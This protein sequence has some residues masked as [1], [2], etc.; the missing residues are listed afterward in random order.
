MELLLDNSGQPRI[1]RT[2]VDYTIDLFEMIRLGQYDIVTQY[3][4]HVFKHEPQQKL[5]PTD[6]MIWDLRGRRSVADVQWEIEQAGFRPADLPTLLAFGAQHPDVQRD[7]SIAGLGFTW[8]ENMFETGFPAL[9]YGKEGRLLRA[10]DG[11]RG[12]G[13]A[14]KPLV[15]IET[16][17]VIDLKRAI[18]LEKAW[19]PWHDQPDPE[20]SRRKEE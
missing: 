15:Y 9:S 10:Y 13:S 2:Q 12:I 17:I 4:R 3:V 11:Y 1:F 5:I 20:L 19:K 18:E 7:S 16:P 8:Q 6:L 14:F